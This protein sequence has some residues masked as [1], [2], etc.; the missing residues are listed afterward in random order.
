MLKTLSLLLY[1]EGI[2]DFHW[3]FQWWI[4][5]C[6]QMIKLV[7]P[8]RKMDSICI[9]LIILYRF[10][11]KRD[12]VINEF[13]FHLIVWMMSCYTIYNYR[14]IY[15]N[16][17]WHYKGSMT[18]WQMFFGHL[19]GPKKFVGEYFNSLYTYHHWR[20][21]TSVNIDCFTLIQWNLPTWGR[22]P[23]S[24]DHPRVKEKG[25]LSALCTSA[26]F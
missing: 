8:T 9:K 6:D 23:Y 12:C 26:A 21:N 5:I 17:R 3:F 18:V 13:W 4:T 11:L 14:R 25:K 10:L 7:F 15:C 24:Q 20:C 2:Y 1:I 16:D 22:M 19:L